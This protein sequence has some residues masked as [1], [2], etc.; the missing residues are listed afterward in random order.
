MPWAT[1]DD[2]FDLTGENVAAADLTKAQDIIE[3]FAGVTE[4]ASDQG[5]ISGRNLR[6]LNRAVAYQAAWM[7]YH[8]DL[9][10]HMDAETQSQDG[11]SATRAHDNA[12]LLAPLALRFLR[13]VSWK[14][15]PLRA[16]N[17]SGYTSD[18]RGDRDSAVRDDR[19]DWTP[20][21]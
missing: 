13:R 9:Y 20:L 18:E 4:D 2:V 7:P 6:L 11:V 12:R 17:R 1:A 16:I 14:Q 3:L 10:T 15:S 8:P 5:L 21:P 19:F